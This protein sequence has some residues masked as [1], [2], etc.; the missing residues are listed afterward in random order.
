MRTPPPLVGRDSERAFLERLLAGVRAGESRTLVLHGGPGSGKTALLDSVVAAA[1]DMRVAQLVGN[2]SESGLPFAGLHSLLVSAA[3][4]CGGL[5]DDQRQALELAFGAG[6]GRRRSQRFLIGLATLALLS[7]AAEEGPLLCVV[8]ELEW[9]DPPSAEA[10]AFTARRLHA[11]MIGFVFAARDGSGAATRVAGLPELAVDPLGRDD[12]AALLASG[13]AGR[14]D[15]RVAARLLAEAL[16]NPLALLELPAELTAAQLAGGA[17]LPA[18]LQFGR[19]LEETFLR[20]VR[21]LPDATRTLL[22]LTAAEPAGETALVW[23]AAAQLGVGPEAAGPAEEEGLLRVN[24]R[25]AFRQPLIRAA[26]YAAAPSAERRRVHEA[27]A[28]VLLADGDVDRRAWHRGAAATAPEEAVAA[29][30]ERASGPATRR[31]GYAAAAALLTRAAELTP[32]RG[33]RV[34]RALAAVAAELEAGAPQRAAALLAATQPEL[35]GPLQQARSRALRA[36]IA[37]AAGD[38]SRSARRLLEAAQ[39][40]EPLDLRQARDTYLQAL[41]AAL[42]A[43]TL[44]EEGDVLAVATAARAASAVPAGEATPAD[45]LLDGL[46]TVY[47]QG[48]AAGAP[49]LRL[50]IAAADD[51]WDLRCLGLAYNHAPDLWDD[52][53]MQVLATRRVELARETGALTALPSALAQLGGYEVL[54]GR[55]DVAEDRFA[56]ARELAAATGSPGL[57]GATDPGALGVAAWRGHEEET[58]A[59][60]ATC[61]GDAAARGLGVFVQL[62]QHALAV[63]ELGLGHYPAAL[64]AARD[65]A[66]DDWLGMR[67]LP[68]LVE[69]AVRTGEL[70]LAAAMTATLAGPARASGTHWGLGILARSRALVAEGGDADELYRTAIGHL[71]QS[72]V[73]P[74]LARTRLLYG[75][76]LRRERR[77]LDAR[78]QL[79]GAYDAFASFGADGFAERA[80]TELAAT[81]ERVNRAPASRDIL[82]AHERRIAGLAAVGEPNQAIAEQLFLSPRTIEYHLRTI[83]RKLGLASRTQLAAYLAGQRLDDG[84]DG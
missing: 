50:A 83:Y 1:A 52:A 45:A 49:L 37:A 46:A 44:G 35:A 81:G 42:Y 62:A 33:E 5:P 32:D 36:A 30:L 27:L 56:E 16:G 29:E 11:E 28:A 47:T 68:D 25:I 13:V 31:G 74:Q 19:R 59:L 40:L 82:T 7:G 57:I 9:V 63:L 61:I 22:L 51:D 6:D 17:P 78:R 55:L 53:A 54:V 23:Q 76:W 71:Q 8:D 10:L 66:A 58:Y 75:E 2:E 21:P 18:T 38:T 72:R 39:L 43:G 48:R 79:R 80:R 26:V 3:A 69:A 4:A 64:T 14:L 24:G 60:A 73:M 65:A 20:R 41:A 70:S 84:A 34:G 12:A 15:P 67:A 77:R